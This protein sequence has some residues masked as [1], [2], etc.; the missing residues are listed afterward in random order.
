[1]HNSAYTVDQLFLT[2]HWA[3]GLPDESDG[4]YN[5]ETNKQTIKNTTGS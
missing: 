2:F 3:L 4:Q 5:Q 1:M